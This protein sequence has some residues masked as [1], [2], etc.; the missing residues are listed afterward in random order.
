ADGDVRPVAAL[1]LGPPLPHAAAMIASTATGTMRRDRRRSPP[2]EPRRSIVRPAACVQA[3]RERAPRGSLCIGPRGG[4]PRRTLRRGERIGWCRRA[5]ARFG[6][7]RGYELTAATGVAAVPAP[8]RTLAP[9][10]APMLAAALPGPSR[11]PAILVIS[12]LLRT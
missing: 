11:V 12:P 3:R 9:A 1:R 7:G 10:L 4:P 2:G 8:P 5:C 6:G